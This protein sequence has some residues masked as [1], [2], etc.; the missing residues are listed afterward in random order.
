MAQIPF[1]ICPNSEIWFSNRE[2][3]SVKWINL[4]SISVFSFSICVIL[5]FSVEEY[6]LLLCARL[7]NRIFPA[8]KTSIW[9]SYVIFNFRLS[10]AIS[11]N[12]SVIFI[13]SSSLLL[14]KF[15]TSSIVALF[16]EIFSRSIFI[17]SVSLA[18]SLVNL[19]SLDRNCSIE[20]FKVSIWLK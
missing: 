7:S 14:I 11:L 13:Y 9:L 10:N 2:Y 3:L 15:A 12:F 19:R 1:S 8:S 16:A 17:S 4:A 5:I 6:L 20:L 18:I